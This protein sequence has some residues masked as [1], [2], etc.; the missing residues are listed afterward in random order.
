[1]LQ[2]MG[3]QGVGHDLVTEQQQSFRMLYYIHTAN[4]LLSQHSTIQN[5]LMALQFSKSISQHPELQG[6]T[7][8]PSLSLSNL[9]SHNPPARPPQGV[10]CCCDCDTHT[11]TS[12]PLCW[13]I[14]L[15]EC[16]FSRDPLTQFLAP[17]MSLLKYHFLSEDFFLPCVQ[18]QNP[19]QL[20]CSHTITGPLK[21][22]PYSCLTCHTFFFF[23]NLDFC[24]SPSL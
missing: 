21:L 17:F 16:S 2:S 3:S 10:H 5:P 6:R 7:R 22:S 14:A 20:R 15:L 23:I 18:F 4:N 12:G 24:L 9:I 1:M 19:F 13:L 11:L 8:L